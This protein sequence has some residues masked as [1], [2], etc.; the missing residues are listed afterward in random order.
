MISWTRAIYASLLVSVSGTAGHVGDG[1]ECVYNERMYA[2]VL[3]E[4][5]GILERSVRTRVCKGFMMGATDGRHN[6]RK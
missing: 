3:G 2:V 5:P 6:D 1:V 4:N